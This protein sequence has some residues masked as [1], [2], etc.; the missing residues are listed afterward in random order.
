ML[1]FRRQYVSMKYLLPVVMWLRYIF[2]R[3][4]REALSSAK[5]QISVLLGNI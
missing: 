2:A 5:F 3:A 1:F 4:E